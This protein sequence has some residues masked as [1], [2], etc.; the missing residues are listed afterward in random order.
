MLRGTAQGLLIQAFG[1]L[2]DSDFLASWGG[3]RRG[4][5]SSHDSVLSKCLQQVLSCFLNVVTPL[6]LAM[7]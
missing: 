7:P 3:R 2:G 4:E 6:V 5:A 1:G